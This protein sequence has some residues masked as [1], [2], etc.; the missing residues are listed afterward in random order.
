MMNNFINHAVFARI[1]QS[2]RMN[3][4]SIFNQGMMQPNPEQYFMQKYGN[5]PAVQQAMQIVRGRSPQEINNYLDNLNTTFK[6]QS[7]TA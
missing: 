5:N 2:E 7:P 4:E 3:I 1:S 6:G